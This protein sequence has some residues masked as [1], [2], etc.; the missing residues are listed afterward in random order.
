MSKTSTDAQRD[1]LDEQINKRR[2]A[3]NRHNRRAA[4]AR[5]RGKIFGDA[6]ARGLDCDVKR[7]LFAWACRLM[8]NSEEDKAAGKHYGKVCAKCRAV[9]YALLWKFHNAKTGQC[10]PSYEAIAEAADCARSTA[11]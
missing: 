2:A 8:R 10:F 1:A 9:L 5:K 6:Y 4:A 11:G 3:L 7:R